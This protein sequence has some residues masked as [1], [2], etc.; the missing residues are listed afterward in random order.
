MATGHIGQRGPLICGEML[1]SADLRQT[2][3]C[4]QAIGNCISFDCVAGA[5]G[6]S[7]ADRIICVTLQRID[8]Q[9]ASVGYNQLSAGFNAVIVGV[10]VASNRRF[11]FRGGLDARTIAIGNR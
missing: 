1:Q 6:C 10:G 7:K 4:F 3:N 5:F 2:A 11:D 8:P 9:D